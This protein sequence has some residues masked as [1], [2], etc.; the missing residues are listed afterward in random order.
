MRGGQ[1]CHAD[2]I[3]EDGLIWVVR[4][5]LSSG[6][7]PPQEVRDYVLQSEAA[8]MQFLQG[9]TSIPSPRIFDWACESDPLNTVGVGYILMEK[10]QGS[11]LD[12]QKATAAQREKVVWQLADVMIEIERHPFEALGSLV[13]APRDKMGADAVG[14]AHKML[15]VQS[16]AQHSTFKSGK[17]SQPLGPFR[18]SKEALYALVN[19][20]LS[21]IVGGEIGTAAN[22]LDVFLAHRFRLEVLDKVWN[23]ATE[24]PGTAEN[25]EEFFLKHPDDKGD[26]IFVN[27]NFDIVGIIDWEWCSTTSKEEAF[28]SPCMM[29][30]IAAFYDGSNELADEELLLANIFRDNGRNDLAGY[31]IN[32][33]RVQRL[34]FALGPGGPSNEDKKTF[35]QLFIGLKR[36]FDRESDEDEVGSTGNEEEEFNIWRTEALAKWKHEAL[37]RA[38]VAST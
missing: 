2:V 12:W 5:K 18:S 10:L 25:G 1:N 17:G 27:A 15:Q 13:A 23:S 26:H 21:M 28:S 33:R 6:T 22:A 19:A 4:F 3:F 38:L 11:P 29:W 8:T 31:V 37:L 24:T 34:F 7:S 14:S 30:P 32:G 36:A 9:H 16:L 35:A 20:H